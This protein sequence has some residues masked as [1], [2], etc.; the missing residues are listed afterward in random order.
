MKQQQDEKVVE[1]VFVDKV[2]QSTLDYYKRLGYR[3]ETIIKEKRK[4]YNVFESEAKALE[5]LKEL[6]N[7]EY[8][9]TSD[10]RI[11]AKNNIVYELEMRNARLQSFP[12]SI[13]KL[14]HLTNLIELIWQKLLIG[15]KIDCKIWVMN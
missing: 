1:V 13:L 5:E 12:E 15:L 7:V 2:K 14:K 6:A 3:E 9:D 4:A 11:H 8:F 10:F